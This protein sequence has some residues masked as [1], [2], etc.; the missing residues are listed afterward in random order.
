[1]PG[2]SFES[3]LLYVHDII[4]FVANE[5]NFLNLNNQAY[6][7]KQTIEISHIW[8]ILHAFCFRF[9]FRRSYIPGVQTW[10]VYY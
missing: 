5:R 4:F 3:S 2:A 9:S 10:P 1:M 6:E 7:L 8:K